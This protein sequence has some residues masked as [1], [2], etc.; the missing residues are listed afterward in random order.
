M[1][2]QSDPFILKFC[3]ERITL[4]LISRAAPAPPMCRASFRFASDM[5]E[6]VPQAPGRQLPDRFVV[7]E[8]GGKV[9][10]GFGFE[11]IPRLVAQGK[12]KEAAAALALLG[13]S[14]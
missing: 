2:T 1:S 7:E 10:F 9:G 11:C 4:Q 13:G 12:P 14:K 8:A 5:F 3:A 6:F